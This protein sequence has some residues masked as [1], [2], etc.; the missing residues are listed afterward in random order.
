MAEQGRELTVG[1][2]V[3]RSGRLAKLGDPLAFALDLLR[4]LLERE[5]VRNGGRRHPVR[6]VARDSRSTAEGA[7]QAVRELL[8]EEDAR[9]VLTLAGTEVLPAVAD[10]CE[11][12]GVPCLSSTFPWQVYY[13]GRDAHGRRPFRWTYHFCWGLD[14]IAETFAD[15]WEHAAGPGRTV[16]C[17]WNDGPQGTWSRDAERGFA[18]VARARGHRLVDPGGYR[19]PADGLDALVDAF[20][21]ADADIVTSAATARDLAV[22]RAAVA[23]RG[24]P[25]PR[26]ITCSRWLAYPPTTTGGGDRPAQDRVA[27]LVYWTPAHP[28]RSS[29]DGMTAAELAEAYEQG[30]GGQWLQPLGLAYALFE[31]ARHALATAD[32]PG[33]PAAVA[34]AVGRTRL[35][36]VAG[37]LDWTAGPVP[38][39]ATIRLAGGQW[40]PGTRHPYEL[41]VVTN[42]RVEG[43]PA[44]ADLLPLTASDGRSG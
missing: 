36:T 40:Q 23:G 25:Q 20:R 32:D 14:D 29:L 35:E 3:A 37:P 16:G 34:A 5:G 6:L 1:V 2:V 27:T 44:A 28:Y 4:P 18:P 11:R 41:A 22:F 21:A 10:A 19:E 13:Y 24:G 43:L 30:T 39:V 17:L 33:D 8:A 38:N 26:M 12:A 31:V 9:I 7:R 42:R 15:L